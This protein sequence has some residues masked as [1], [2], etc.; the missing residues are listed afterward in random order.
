MPGAAARIRSDAVHHAVFLPIFGELAEP[1]TVAD[2]AAEAEARGWDGVFIWDHM[3]YRPPVTD[4]ADPWVTLAAMACA[5]T[6]VRIGP[7]VTPL[8][9]RRPQKLARETV[10]VDRLSRG[11]LVLGAGLGGN[12]GR[13]LS[14]LGEETDAVE[15]GRMLDEGLDLL[16]RLWSGEQVTHDGPH[17]Q[18]DDV[19][20]RPVAV[21][22]PRIPVWL[23]AVYP[24][25]KPLRRAARYDGLFP[26]GLAG[27]EQLREVLDV[28]AAERAELAGAAADPGGSPG[29]P[30]GP[31]DVAVQG[32]ADQSP[33][34]WEPAGATWWLVRFDPYTVTAA[35]VRD[36]IAAGPPG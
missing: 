24:H 8:P 15:R 4:V 5:T 14:A 26:I 32:P 34:E 23:A 20:F 28:V 18:A 27:P 33:A 21:Q 22:D 17:Y 19:R 35:E 30:S 7:M 12:P 3:L 1:R 6:R 10:S 36:V 16:T 25:R 29:V 31:F 13:E 2:L 11:R 9:R